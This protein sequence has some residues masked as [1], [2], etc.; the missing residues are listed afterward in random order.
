MVFF[1]Q[2][3]TMCF[4]DIRING[5]IHQDQAD[6][7]GT[8][9]G[10]TLSPKAGGIWRWEFRFFDGRSPVSNRR[11]Y[12]NVPDFWPYVGIFPEILA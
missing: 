1:K 5:G 8:F 7:R 2:L 12:V 10:T 4:K 3:I 11:R 6:Q 9:A